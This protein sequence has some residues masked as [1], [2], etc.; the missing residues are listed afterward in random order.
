MAPLDR[1]TIELFASLAEH[2][3]VGAPVVS[4]VANKIFCSPTDLRTICT[5]SR[6]TQSRAADVERFLQVGSEN[7]L[8][9]RIS[10]LT[11]SP[12]NVC[13]HETLAPLLTGAALYRK[14]VHRD[15]DVVNIVLTEPPSPSRF[16]A[17]L[18]RTLRGSWGL[19][20]TA[21]TLPALAESAQ[22][23]FV[24]MTPYF[25]SIGVQHMMNLF[26]RTAKD[27]RRILIVRET[28][29][30]A[31]SREL[32]AASP[33]LTKL[34]VQV[35][36]FRL[37]RDVGPGNET[38]HAKVVLADRHT[39]YV[40]SFNMNKW[41]FQYSLELGLQVKGQAASRIAD[42]LSAVISVSQPVNLTN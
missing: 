22:E 15:V 14:D 6:L 16:A 9:K 29:Q 7:D 4:S 24:I 31:I 8:F 2:C 30:G 37:D 17:E 5:Y 42:I 18:E 40:G 11:W 25:D 12:T 38:F 28:E 21:S 36:N 32:F 35:L 13:V 39:A 19:L 34:Q 26:D 27:A 33:A 20:D 41:S 1:A 10:A 23:S 3:E